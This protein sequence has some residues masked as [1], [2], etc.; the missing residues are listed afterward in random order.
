[1]TFSGSRWISHAFPN[2]VLIDSILILTLCPKEKSGRIE[3]VRGNVADYD[4]AAVKAG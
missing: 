2:Q 3:L 1:M 4:Y